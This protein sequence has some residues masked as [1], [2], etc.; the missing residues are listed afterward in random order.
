MPAQ[1]G[2]RRNFKQSESCRGGSTGNQGNK[3]R[4]SQGQGKEQGQGQGQGRGKGQSCNGKS[5]GGQRRGQGN[6]GR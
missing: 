6:E 1:E 3:A 4:Q 2:N 5:G